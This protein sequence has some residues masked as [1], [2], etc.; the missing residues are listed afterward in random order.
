[1]LSEKINVEK[2]AIHIVINSLRIIIGFEPDNFSN[3]CKFFNFILENIDIFVIF[4][5]LITKY[6]AI[7]FLLTKMQ[8]SNR[9]EEK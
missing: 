3:F 6:F 7:N 1:M 4:K 5:V 8:D 9:D 2:K